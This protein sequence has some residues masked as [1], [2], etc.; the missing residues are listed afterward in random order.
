M[1]SPHV[2]GV[3]ALMLSVN[4]ALTPAV[5]RQLLRTTA[6]QFPTRLH[7][8]ALWRGYCQCVGRAQRGGQCDHHPNANPRTNGNAN[9]NPNQDAN[10]GPNGHD[11]CQ[12]TNDRHPLFA[13]DSAGGHITTIPPTIRLHN[14]PMLHLLYAKTEF[15]CAQ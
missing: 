9:G 11:R 10:A 13:A 14:S 12:P 1:A 15:P 2:A 4:G 3:A 5:V 6:T 8:H 7:T